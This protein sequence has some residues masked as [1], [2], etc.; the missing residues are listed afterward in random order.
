MTRSRIEKKKIRTE[1]L[2]LRKVTRGGESLPLPAAAA[3]GVRFRS[4]APPLAGAR[5]EL[6][7]HLGLPLA[8]VRRGSGARARAPPP[9]RS[10]AA[11]SR[12]GKRARWRGGWRRRRRFLSN[13]PWRPPLLTRGR[14]EWRGKEEWR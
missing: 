12:S 2:T 13:G 3:R 5:T 4:H 1:T 9:G 8:W 7:N 11:R 14:K 6:Q 10:T